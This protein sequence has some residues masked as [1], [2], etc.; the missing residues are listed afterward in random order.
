MLIIVYYSNSVNSLH[1]A[2]YV[3]LIFHKT[4]LQVVEWEVSIEYIAREC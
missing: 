1:T 3:I 2:S 4:F